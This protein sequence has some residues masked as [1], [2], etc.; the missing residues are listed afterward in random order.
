MTNPMTGT[1]AQD[2]IRRFQAPRAGKDKVVPL[3]EAVRNS[4]RPGMA[5]HFAFLHNRPTAAAVEVLRQFGRGTRGKG[6]TGSSPDFTLLVLFAAGPIA[7]LVS[8]GLAPH[9]VTTLVC[10]PYPAPGPSLAAQRAVASGALTIEHWSVLSYVARLKAA[11][12]GLPAMP[13]RMLPGTTIEADNHAHLRRRT[14]GVVEVDALA[15]DLSFLHAPCADRFGNVLLAP[16]YGEGVWGCFA[17][18][19]GVVVTVERIVEPDVIA[20]HSHLLGLPASRVQSVSVVPFGA[21]PAGLATAGIE[22]V[23]PYGD[24][25]EHYAAMRE[26]ARTP[27]QLA[28]FVDEWLYGPADHDALLAKLGARR[29]KELKGKARA[30]SWRSELLDAMARVDLAAAPTPT[31]RMICAAAGVLARK[32]ETAGHGAILSGLGAGNLAAWLAHARVAERGAPPMLVAELGM[33][34]YAP[35]PCDPFLFNLRN[36]ATCSMV[37]DAETALGTLIGGA[38]A[39]ALASLGAAQVGPDGSFNSTRLADGTLLVGSGGACDVA[40]GADEVVIVM[41]AGRARLVE[42]LPYVTG[43]GERV[44]AVVTDVGVFEK[45]R[46]AHALRLTRLVGPLVGGTVETHTREALARCGFRAEVAP[47]L[48]IEELAAHRDIECLRLYDP[49]RAFLGALG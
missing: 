26:S 48:A 36:L 32:V 10:E 27:E 25:V 40:S 47:D 44:T 28:G 45:A 16:P 23:E 39:H 49:E 35:R 14:A 29:L 4:V 17:A 11:A 19:E 2:W 22:G 1:S 7:A 37:A 24:D 3:D 31:E 30:D 6:P 5:L 42:R 20:R 18:K 43:S 41:H 21:H 9:L 13:V 15:P 38:H 33:H 34:G 12:L 46:G 8:E